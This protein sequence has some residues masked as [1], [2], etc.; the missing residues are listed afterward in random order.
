MF[1]NIRMSM[2][3]AWSVF[4]VIGENII[5]CTFSV[6]VMNRAQ[7]VSGVL[8]WHKICYI[9]SKFI[10]LNIC[11]CFICT[12][13]FLKKGHY[14]KP[15]PLECNYHN[16][17]RFTRGKFCLFWAHLMQQS[18]S[19]F[20]VLCLSEH[21]QQEWLTLLQGYGHGSSLNFF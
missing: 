1:C 2:L 13:F 19:C 12:F 4:T 14:S 16:T 17:I 8:T 9:H 18:D 11:L 15:L 5:S 7:T 10:K 6:A 21:Y 20:I 3:Y